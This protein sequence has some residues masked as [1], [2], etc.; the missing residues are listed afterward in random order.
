MVPEVGIVNHIASVTGTRFAVKNITTTKT[1]HTA[2][3]REVKFWAI[4]ERS[5]RRRGRERT[6]KV[7]DTKQKWVLN[8]IS[9]FLRFF[10]LV[11][12]KKFSIFE[13]SCNET[14]YAH[15]EGIAGGTVGARGL[16]RCEL[17]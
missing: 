8:S 12:G 7:L 6:E 17:V 11:L 14:R 16:V 3:A 15:A 1:E 9:P 5:V 13:L 4:R 2:R 10:F